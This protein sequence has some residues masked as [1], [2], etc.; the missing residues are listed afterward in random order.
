MV[1]RAIDGDTLDV[2]IDGV[3]TPIGLLGAVAPP[4]N[5]PC[6][7]EAAARLSELAP[8]AASISLAAD[9]AYTGLDPRRRV[10]LYYAFASD[11]TSIDETLVAEG[12]AHA[13][14]PSASNTETLTALE[15]DAQANGRG[16][17]WAS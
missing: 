14:N 12:L 8:A 11:G 13:A 4:L 3:R 1:N 10:V 6:G 15:A 7:P 16:C 2:A 17:L 5:Q 9:P